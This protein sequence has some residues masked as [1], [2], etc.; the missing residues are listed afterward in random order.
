MNVDGIGK[1]LYSSLQKSVI[2]YHNSQSPLKSL[3]TPNSCKQ[4]EANIPHQLATS[5]F[6][7]NS[8]RLSSSL[9][10]AYASLSKLSLLT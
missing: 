6:P 2:L 4:V 10:R 9:N 7:L 5:L 3:L 1:S 8:N